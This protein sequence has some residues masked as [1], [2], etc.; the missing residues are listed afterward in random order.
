MRKVLVLIVLAAVL[1]VSV[2]LLVG[3]RPAVEPVA[4]GR[5]SAAQTAQ[6]E[7]SPGRSRVD[8]EER[9]RRIQ[10]QSAARAVLRQRISEAMEAREVAATMRRV[11]AEP[12]GAAPVRARRPGEQ[13][14]AE[15]APPAPGL[16][17]RTGNHGYLTKVLS[18]DLMPLADECYELARVQQPKLA[19]MLVLELELLGDEEL[20]GVIDSVDPGSAN[21]LND[22]GL[23]E[24]VRESLLATSLPPPEQGGRD[25]ISLSMRFSP[26][27]E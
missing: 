25:A 20:G 26:D 23:I 16:L 18:Q 2:W 15:E 13:E 14:I 22:P 19:G 4:E 11:A 5:Q 8:A 17:D 3:S 9:T 1:V 6:Q 27:D 10:E 7:A 12:A 24:C 21:E